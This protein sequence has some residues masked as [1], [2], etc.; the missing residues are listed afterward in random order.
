MSI[1]NLDYASYN[2]LTNLASVNANEVNTDILT[3]SD[4]DISDL[5][6]DMLEGIN[7]N[8]TIQEQIN[9]LIAGL[10]TIGYWG[11]F[12]STST[13]GNPVAN[14]ANLITVNNSDL[15]NNQVEIGAT[16]SQIKVLNKGVYNFQF[17]AQ[18]EK[19]DGGKD[20]FS[21]WFLK[22]GTNISNSNS[23]FSIHDSNGKLIAALNFVISLEA[24]DYIQLA[25]SSADTNMEL[26]FVAAQTTPTRPA[27]PSV[28]ITVCQIANILTG[29]VGPTGATGTP[30]TNGAEGSTGPTG[31]QGIQGPTGAQGIQGIQG[32]TGPTG[33]TG[34]QGLTGP[35]GLQGIQGI[36]GPQGSKGDKGDKGNQGDTGPAGAG[37]DGP[38]AIAAL[39]LAGVAEAT[40]IA[41]GAAASTALSQN[42][43]QDAVISGLAADIGIL[44]TD[45]AALQVKTTDQS[46]G[47]LTGTTFSGKVNVGNV[48]LNLSTASTFGNGISSS[49]A[50]ISTLGT[51]QMDSLLVNQNLEI[52]N[53]TFITSGQLYVTRTLLTSQKKIVL[54]DNA[55]GDDYDYLGFWTDSGSASK[56][57]LNSEIDGITGS[58]FQWYYGDGL[59]L[60]RTLAKYLSSAEEIGYTP[61]AT[62]LKSSGASQQIQLIKDAANNKVRIDMF[63]DTAGVNTFDGQIIQE[64][65]NSLDDNKGTLTLQSGAVAISGLNTGVQMQSNTSTL[66]QAGTTLTLTSTGETEINCVA[67]D[68]N[69]TGAITLDTDDPI[70]LTSTANGIN[71]SG[72]G[73]NTIL[74]TTNINTTG[75]T[76]TSIGNAG[77]TN[78]ILG[79]TNINRTGT[80][81]TSIGNNTGAFN[82][83][84]GIFNIDA[85]GAITMDTD[86][87]ITLTSTANGINLSSFGEQDI[88]CGSLD[89]NSNGVITI[90]SISNN[91]IISG[92]NLTLES[93]TE[94]VL[95]SDTTMNLT[96]GGQL[97]FSPDKLYVNAITDVE[98]QADA[99]LILGA[100]TN[101]YLSAGTGFLSVQSGT[102]INLSATDYIDV[103]DTDM[104]IQQTN[105]SPFDSEYQIGYTVSTTLDCGTVA[106]SLSEET[107]FTIPSK[108]VWL[109]IMGYEWVSVS[110]TI[111]FKELYV[112]S[113]TASS[114][115]LAAGLAYLEGLDDI[116]TTNRTS[117]KG[118]I[119]G[120]YVATGSTTA[121]VNASALVNIGTRPT[122]R[123]QYSYTRL[124]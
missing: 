76:A 55:T 107:T 27:T 22:N 75:T 91:T 109:I 104:H 66:I 3:K 98:L 51:S 24:N 14:T 116:T 106:A 87:P 6:F 40:A 122:L 81:A 58:A 70:T 105:Y 4:P 26:K 101:A 29:P 7:T 68:I 77:T 48:V 74:G 18:Y 1:S 92:G 96:C 54:Y 79:I 89:I 36:Q 94:M 63:G 99:E 8:Q 31:A 38:I 71:L 121:Y 2:Y 88:T 97:T 45:V 16:S 113:I 118:T 82:L 33:P 43:A 111:E 59:G 120:V 47:F 57:F 84:S 123:I 34:L 108:G 37:G 78:T 28:I 114:S 64:K 52:T 85:T 115:R 17:S 19:T 67:F 93:T 21:L 60:S 11:A 83:N 103:V 32:L 80:A 39:A 124:G 65:G 110:N 5:Q 95:D 41:A 44:E 90:N 56:K 102:T 69:A 23:E 112:S 119:C 9:G 12:F 20:D 25:W 10:E 13:Q 61:K 42:T 46:W 35:T 62:F 100:G 86:D 50:I 72:F 53:D 73:T 49:A 15:S 30:G 117:P